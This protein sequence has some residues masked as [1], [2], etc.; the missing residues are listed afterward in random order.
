M[1]VHYDGWSEQFDI[2]CD[3]DLCDLHPVGWCQRTGHPLDPPPGQADT[4]E[5]QIGQTD[6]SERQTGQADTSERQT[7]QADTSERQTGRLRLG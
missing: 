5:R 7:G 2:W 1:Q 6:T 3:S 4:S